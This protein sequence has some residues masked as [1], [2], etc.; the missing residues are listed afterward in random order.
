MALWDNVFPFGHWRAFNFWDIVFP[1]G[2]KGL[3]L[4]CTKIWSSFKATLSYLSHNKLTRRYLLLLG[5]VL[6]GHC[7][8]W[9]AQQLFLTPHNSH[10][11]NNSENNNENW[12]G[13]ILGSNGW[14]DSF[15]T[16]AHVQI[17]LH[18]CS[19]CTADNNIH[20]CKPG[21]FLG[22]SYWYIANSSGHWNQQ[23]YE[24]ENKNMHSHS[25]AVCLEFMTLQNEGISECLT[26][27]VCDHR[28]RIQD[29][30]SQAGINQLLVVTGILSED[31]FQHLF[32]WCFMW[33][34]QL[35]NINILDLIGT[36]QA[37]FE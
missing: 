8:L 4:S 3:N 9:H 20:C 30:W 19:S 6:S 7:S 5:C 35:P 14:H 28:F 17:Q 25:A 33:V 29:Y 32:W 15:H 26:K 27:Y 16:D 31:K 11:E 18:I 24:V 21:L 10:N 37:W 22:I 12:H 23:V 34:C 2:H 13:V 36:N 1:F